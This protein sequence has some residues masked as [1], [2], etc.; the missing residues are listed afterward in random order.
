MGNVNE[1]LPLVNLL[2]WAPWVILHIH[3]TR[4]TYLLTWTIC[5]PTLLLLTLPNFHITKCYFLCG[6]TLKRKARQLA[7][8]HI[9][10]I[11]AFLKKCKL[12]GLGMVGIFFN[13]LI[14]SNLYIQC[15]AWTHKPEIKGRVSRWL[16]QPGALGTL[17]LQMVAMKKAKF[18]RSI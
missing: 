3:N 12:L 1:A 13:I 6:E 8:P 9:L 5:F 17:Q 2:V 4:I 7:Q 11:F 14:L 15:G 18:F 16:N 10:G